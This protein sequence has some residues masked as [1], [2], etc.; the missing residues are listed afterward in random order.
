[1]VLSLSK[2]RV[3]FFQEDVWLA[4]IFQGLFPSTLCLRCL[5]TEPVTL[6]TEFPPVGFRIRTHC[7]FPFLPRP[8]FQLSHL[9]RSVCREFSTSPFA[10]ARCFRR[11]ETAPG[12]PCTTSLVFNSLQPPKIWDIGKTRGCSQWEQDAVEVERGQRPGSWG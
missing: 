5:A 9:I 6:R 7:F 1:V 3:F 2:R 8:S 10:S 11:A 4:D 12:Y